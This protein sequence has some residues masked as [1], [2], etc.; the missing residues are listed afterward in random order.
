MCV[1]ICCFDFFLKKKEEKKKRKKSDENMISGL[2]K[3]KKN[4]EKNNENS[5]LKVDACLEKSPSWRVCK[6]IRTQKDQDHFLFRSAY[7]HDQHV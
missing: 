7:W 4:K 6:L 1:Q 5:G 2:K 3:K